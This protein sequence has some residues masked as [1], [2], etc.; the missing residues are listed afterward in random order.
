MNKISLLF[1]IIFFTRWICAQSIQINNG[2]S[3]YVSSGADICAGVYGNISGNLYGE[4]TQCGDSSLPVEMIS[5]TGNVIDSKVELIWQTATELNNYGFEV[6]RKNNETEWNKIGFVNGSG[7]SSTIKNY[8]FTDKEIAGGNK[9]FYRLKQIDFNGSFEYSDMIEIEIIPDR[10]VLFQ[11][12]P[13]PFNPSTKIRYQLPKAGN[14]KITVFDIL[15]ADVITLVDEKKEAG[16]Y[17]VEFT[18]QNLPSGTYIFRLI[19]GEFVSTK[20]MVLLK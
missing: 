11:N 3:I 10:Y 1:F 15:G 20:K 7:N 18:S 12:Y 14:V 4:G 8:H 5:F 2:A 19:S 6:E 16:I 9:F 17:E 13:N